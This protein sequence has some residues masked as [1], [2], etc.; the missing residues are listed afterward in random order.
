M[1]R[2]RAY[3]R[4]WHQ[5]ETT[6]F[7]Q[8]PATPAKT[9]AAGVAPARPPRPAS[10]FPAGPVARPRPPFSLLP[11][12]GAGA[13]AGTG[14]RRRSSAPARAPAG[15]GPAAR[16]L[17]GPP[18]SPRA[19]GERPPA[20]TPHG[21]H[22][23]GRGPGG[24]LVS[25]APRN[26]SRTRDSAPPAA[27]SSRRGPDKHLPGA[28]GR[29]LGRRRGPAHREGTELGQKSAPRPPRPGLPAGCARPAPPSQRYARSQATGT[30]ARR[31]AASGPPPPAVRPPA[32]R[33]TL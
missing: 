12:A 31:S 23:G 13:G 15:P 2:A 10:G 26:D 9:A 7:R 4:Q 24:H 22:L 25:P 32:L 5:T 16:P 14:Q 11:W 29:G 33:G 6:R 18:G 28:S 27:G 30:S 8:G 20:D 17:H 3:Q 21:A 1:S 19:Q